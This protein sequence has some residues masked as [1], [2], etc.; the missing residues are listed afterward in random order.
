MCALCGVFDV[1]TAFPLSW[2]AGWQRSKSQGRS[3]F[4]TVLGE[5]ISEV[6][7]ELNMLKAKS[8]VV[9]SNLPLKKDGL[10]M[11]VKGQ[12]SD[13]G[14]A[15]YFFLN[16]RTQCIPCDR[17]SRV[18]DNM[19]AIGLSIGALRGLERWG[20]K[21]MVDAAFSGFQALPDYSNTVVNQLRYFEDCVSV[22]QANQ[23]FKHLAKELHP[24]RGGVAN[25]FQEMN[26]QYDQFIK[27]RG[28]S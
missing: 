14:V 1:T 11:V 9:S 8:A 22:E 7:R 24:D 13:V 26:K 10:P 12:P 19:H 15:V 20:A 3:N 2:P 23:R 25:D 5:A 4:K 18:E 17:W 27:T 28:A 6:F 21:E 16:G